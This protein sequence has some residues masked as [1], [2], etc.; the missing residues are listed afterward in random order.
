M[1]KDYKTTIR[2]K[3]EEAAKLMT[4]KQVGLCNGIIHT[5][6]AAS[7]VAAFIP[8]P[9]ADA[10][11]ISAAQIT[12]VVSLGAVFKQK[13]T[14]SVAKA[15][16]SAAASTFA[17]RQL[18][19]LIPA[20]GWAISSAVAAGITEA[21]GWMVAVDMAND[22]YNNTKKKEA[23]RFAA[24]NEM[25]LKYYKQTADDFSYEAEDFS[26]DNDDSNSVDK[27]DVKMLFDSKYYVGKKYGGATQ[28]L[29]EMGFTNVKIEE[30]KDIKK[31]NDKKIGTVSMITIG[32]NP[33]FKSGDIKSS[34][35][36]VVVYYHSLID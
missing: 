13:L 15:L 11:P 22:Y 5:A 25:E 18:V 3:R 26:V 31:A 28:R 21:I 14:K 32:K 35:D 29:I 20:V 7:G 1:D 23:E 12:M 10:I 36:E 34:T 9:I 33:N 6:A 16:V 2:E 4:K 19:K 30:I 17:G 27:K 8:V 24:E